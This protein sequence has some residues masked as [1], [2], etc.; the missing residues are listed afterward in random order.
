MKLKIKKGDRVTVI[1]GSQKGKTGKVLHVHP[2]KL[3]VTI[4]GVN[5][6]KHHEK[7]KP[8]SPGGIVSKE[9]P[10]HY[11]NVLIAD[12]KTGKPSRVGY[13]TGD[14][15]KERFAKRSGAAL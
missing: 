8:N 4:E 5:M 2:G 11:S 13:R 12:E 7:A 3:Q 15:G 9:G 10:V 14:K 6:R 1:A